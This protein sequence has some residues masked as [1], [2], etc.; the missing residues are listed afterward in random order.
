MG[1]YKGQK[2][3]ID[4]ASFRILIK[5]EYPDLTGVDAM[6]RRKLKQECKKQRLFGCGTDVSPYRFVTKKKHNAD[7][8][9]LKK[10]HK[11]GER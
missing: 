10:L 4:V 1:Y 11:M 5:D 3:R 2:Q 7:S 9:R 6:N 8:A